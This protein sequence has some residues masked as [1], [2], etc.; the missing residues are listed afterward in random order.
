MGNDFVKHLAAR[1]LV[2]DVRRIH[3][4]GYGRKQ[5]DV[6][7]RERARNCRT[8]AHLDLVKYM[9]LDVVHGSLLRCGD[10]ASAAATTWA[11][12]AEITTSNDTTC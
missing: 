12:S 9:I 2:V 6:V 10:A 7:A 3:V 11:L 4:A 1:E 5:H 8:I